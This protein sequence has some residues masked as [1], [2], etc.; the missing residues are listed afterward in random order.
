MF[1]ISGPGLRKGGLEV[2][3]DRN[4]MSLVSFRLLEGGN[5]YTEFSFSDNG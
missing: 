4:D 1:V 3:A 2:V 5:D